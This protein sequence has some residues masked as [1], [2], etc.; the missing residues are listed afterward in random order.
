MWCQLAKSC[1]QP[2]PT[3][4]HT[5][6]VL[7]AVPLLAA[8]ATAAADAQQPRAVITGPREA[9]CGALV[10]LDATASEG[11]GRL[12]VLAAAPEETTFLPV[13]SSTKCLFAS[14]VAG[15][16]EFVLI[17]SGTNANGGPAA[18]IAR[19]SVTLRGSTPPPPPPPDEPTD[20]TQP[21]ETMG[22]A[23]L[24]VLRINQDLTADQAATLTKLRTWSDARP[25]QVS[26]LEFSPEDTD[27]RVAQYVAKLPAGQDL[28]YVFLVRQRRDGRGAVILWKGP[29]PNQPADLQT[30]IEALQ[31]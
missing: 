9:R 24:I 4:W 25:N 5:L 11:L 10:V 31:P 2:K 26:Q 16:Y 27:A 23:T 30:R 12:W 14:P 15:R 13:D 20:P 19:H 3:P 29:L 17:V 1:P 7:L 6:A 21:P 28:P 8:L 18:E 22:A